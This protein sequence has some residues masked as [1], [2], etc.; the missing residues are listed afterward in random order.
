[1]KHPAFILIALAIYTLLASSQCKKSRYEPDNP[2]GLPPA[3]QDGK[4]TF[5][6]LLN[7]EPWVPSGN[8]GPANLTIDFD[9]GINN[10]I[11]GIVAYRTKSAA[12]KT[13]F[14]LGIQDSLRFKTDPFTLPIYKKSIGALSYSTKNECHL[15]H[16]D[17][18]IY[19]TGKIN[20]TK[21]DRNNR[22]VAGT[23]EGVLYKAICGDT[24]K[25]TAGRFDMKY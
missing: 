5:G 16:Y 24:V 11:M 10:G 8:S 7:G 2:Y 21:L 12:D 19:E 25:I 6:F 13:Q 22:I 3:T 20:I 18:T 15:N 23:F 9:E 14:I 4:N 17:T 1:M